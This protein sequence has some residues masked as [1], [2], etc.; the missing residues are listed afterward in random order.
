[1]TLL[2]MIDQYCYKDIDVSGYVRDI[3]PTFNE[4]ELID[5]KTYFD[6]S[7]KDLKEIEKLSK[8]SIEICSKLIIEAGK[9]N[10][11]SYKSQELVRKI[12]G[13]NK[14]IAEKSINQILND[15]IAEASTEHL[16]TIN[17]LT[18]DVKTNQIKTYMKSREIYKAMEK[19]AQE[20]GPLLEESIKAFN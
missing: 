11:S 1:M 10:I 3:K 14:K 18:D 12:T 20:I 15:Y 9:C 8:E 4:N 2:A 5:V 19:G 7:I 13:Y 17:Q 6:K 16:D